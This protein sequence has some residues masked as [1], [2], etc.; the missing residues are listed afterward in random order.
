[1]D[2][3]IRLNTFIRDSI[4]GSLLAKR[5]DGEKKQLLKEQAEFAVRLYR[6]L[7]PE[8]Q[9]FVRLPKGWLLQA[10]SFSAR[11]RGERHRFQLN[12]E[13]RFPS[14]DRERTLQDEGL[15]KEFKQLQERLAK[16]EDDRITARQQGRALLHSVTTVK[17]LLEVWPEVKPFLPK[18]VATVTC[19]LALPVPAL[20]T[21]FR[22]GAK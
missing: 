14:E 16:H 4:I 12:A 22:L 6:V 1:M 13:F 17:K 20:N 15:I 2:N 19:A 11:I 18:D 8:W 7:Y 21:M 9:R 3:N 5:F 10:P